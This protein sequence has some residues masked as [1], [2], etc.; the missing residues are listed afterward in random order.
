M[1]MMII[2]TRVD[3]Y[4]AGERNESAEKRIEPDKE[5]YELLN[6][7]KKR[8][9]AP[10][11]SQFI[12]FYLHAIVLQHMQPQRGYTSREC[13]FGISFISIADV[14]GEDFNTSAAPHLDPTL[15]VW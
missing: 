12:S 9:E 3:V 2:P 1:I 11:K 13:G 10:N 7:F 4:T 8:K 5:M 6:Q 15:V 14:S